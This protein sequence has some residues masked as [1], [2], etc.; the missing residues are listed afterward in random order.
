MIFY[1]GTN[2]YGLRETITQGYLLHKRANKDF[3]NMS[4]CTYLAIDIE[5]ASR[6]GNIILEVQYDPYQNPNKK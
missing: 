2:D 3:P 5:E 4:P 6:Y 1:H